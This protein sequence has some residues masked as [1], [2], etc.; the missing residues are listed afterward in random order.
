MTAPQN[1]GNS[2]Q[3][4]IDIFQLFLHLY[5]STSFLRPMRPCVKSGR[6]F[7]FEVNNALLDMLDTRSFNS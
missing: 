6:D 1:S 5:L 7:R 2:Q 4:L 3:G